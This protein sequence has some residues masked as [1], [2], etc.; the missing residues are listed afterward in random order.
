MSFCHTSDFFHYKFIWTC[1][2]LCTCF[3]IIMYFISIWIETGDQALLNCEIK[4]SLECIFLLFF[5]LSTVCSCHFSHW[6]IKYTFYFKISILTTT[7]IILVG[8][9]NISRFLWNFNFLATTN[10][11]PVSASTD[12]ATSYS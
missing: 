8:L 10:I 11:R 7:G 9:A 3:D 12:L 4:R 5:V 1:L 6:H 2:F